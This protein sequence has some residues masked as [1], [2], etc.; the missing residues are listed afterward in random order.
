[1]SIVVGIIILYYGKIGDFREYLCNG[2]PVIYSL[3][4]SIIFQLFNVLG[5]I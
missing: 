5:Y 3:I 2:Q 1:M 4:G